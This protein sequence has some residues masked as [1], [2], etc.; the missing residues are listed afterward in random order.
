M[1]NPCELIA[2]DPERIPSHVAIIMDGNRRWAETHRVPGMMGHWKGADALTQIVSAASKMGIKVLTVYAFS[3]ENWKRSLEEVES[4]M[5][6][7][8]LYLS[9]QKE[10]MAKEGVRLDAIGNI[11]KLPADVKQVLNEAKEATAQGTKI[12][13]VLAMNYGA[14]DDI[15]RAALSLIEACEKGH[16]KKEEITEELFSKHLDTAKWGDPQLLI[17]TSGES[18]LSNFLLWQISYAEVYITDVLWPDFNETE[19]TK[20]I[21]DF[22]RRERRTGG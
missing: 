15:K 2:L 22:Q 11:E 14:R 12:D 16:I 6:L 17:R 20:A 18:R 3:T 10:R 7:F 1:Q 9:G 4:I 13:L 21:F 8:K 19:L 5:H